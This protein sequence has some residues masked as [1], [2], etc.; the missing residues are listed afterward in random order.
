MT[1]NPNKNVFIVGLPTFNWSL[2]INSGNIANALAEYTDFVP[3]VMVGYDNQTEFKP[4]KR[5]KTFKRRYPDKIFQIF[6][7]FWGCWN[8][9]V[10]LIYKV[11]EFLKYKWIYN[12]FNVKTIRVLGG[13]PM[14]GF[15]D[16]KSALNHLNLYDRVYPISDYNK[17]LCLELGFHQIQ[18]VIPNPI[19]LDK[20]FAIRKISN[21]INE[22]LYI[23][24]NHKWKRAEE[25]IW[26]ASQFKDIVFHVIGGYKDQIDYINEML[27]KYNFPTNVKIHGVVSPH[28]VSELMKLSDLH[29]LP[30]R[31]EGRPKSAIEAAA[32]GLPSILFYGYGAEEYITHQENGI[33]VN[34]KEEMKIEF[35]NLLKKPQLLQ[36][37]SKNTLQVAKQFDVNNII[38]FYE[39][40]IKNTIN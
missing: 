33:L 26:L 5:I 17:K 4:H 25:Y 1:K 38:K 40:E 18:N 37:I 12:L 30:S 36:K 2:D 19:N 24:N 35:E 31:S 13:D 11:N 22:V 16:E 9:E 20:F 39:K 29:I 15:K 10:A 21:E 28:R 3:Y 7:H 34:T 23:G 27:K 8:A 6:G 14:M 32:A